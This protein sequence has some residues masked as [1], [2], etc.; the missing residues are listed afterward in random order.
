[1]DV[2]WGIQKTR[3]KN[4]RQ[5]IAKRRR[6]NQNIELRFLSNRFLCLSPPSSLFRMNPKKLLFFGARVCGG[7]C[8]GRTPGA[9]PPLATW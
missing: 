4:Q 7:G 6:T 8:C 1:M 2:P 9:A 5:G 3:S